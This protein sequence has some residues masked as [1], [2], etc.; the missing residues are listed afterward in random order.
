[1]NREKNAYDSIKNYR[2][3]LGCSSIRVTVLKTSLGTM[4]NNFKA[5]VKV[6]AFRRAVRAINAAQKDSWYLAELLRIRLKGGLT[7]PAEV[8]ATLRN[9]KT[10]S[11]PERKSLPRRVA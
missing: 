7:T 8:L 3:P 2:V 4:L 6:I 11:D 1:M 5:I 10:H 9:W